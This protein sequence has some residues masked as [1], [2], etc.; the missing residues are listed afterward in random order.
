MSAKINKNETCLFSTICTF[1]SRP[2]TNTTHFMS[3][4][5]KQKHSWEK[6]KDVHSCLLTV[7]ARCAGRYACQAAHWQSALSALWQFMISQ[8]F[9][10]SNS[11]H[12][13]WQC[14]FSH[15]GYLTCAEL[16]RTHTPY[17]MTD[18]TYQSY[19]CK[20]R[21]NSVQCSHTWR[22]HV[23]SMKAAE[24]KHEGL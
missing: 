4:H 14:T 7:T 24:L 21:L 22:K 20:I 2:D 16:M 5:D 13:W 23:S 10:I 17:D 1:K 8:S 12:K 11:W 18:E 9:E 19:V 15:S 6:K 3:L